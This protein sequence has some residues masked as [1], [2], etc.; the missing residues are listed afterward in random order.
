MNIDELLT[1]SI[2]PTLTDFLGNQLVF[3]DAFKK[4]E[5]FGTPIKNVLELGVYRLP[6]E[7]N[8]NYPGQSTKTLMILGAF[9]KLDK[10]VSLDID[11]C[12]STIEH[13]KKWCKA[14][15]IDVDV[16]NFVQSNSIHFNVLTEFSNGV[17]LIFLD[18][19][20]DDLYPEKLG[21]KG[22]GGAGM[23][24]RE[25][26]HYAPHLSENGRLFVHDTKHFYVE[27]AYG[28]NTAG[29]I[30]R[31][32]AENPNYGFYEHNTNVHGLGQIYRKGSKVEAS[33]NGS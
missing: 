19:N 12:R 27:Q 14:R 31:F 16:H 8:S 23:T 25:I 32:I 24:Y 21:Y 18:T 29:A 9:Y 26:C 2:I 7:P 17:D 3:W 11:D 13:C 4:N 22:S 33:L 1:V 6:G 20:H 28:V 30:E 10:F 15:D 5:E